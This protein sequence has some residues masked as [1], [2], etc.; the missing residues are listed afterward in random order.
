MSRNYLQLQLL[1]AWHAQYAHEFFLSIFVNVENKG[2]LNYIPKLKVASSILVARSIGKV[3]GS[4]RPDSLTL[5]IEVSQ[6]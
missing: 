2:S 3:Q 5:R 1:D 4:I 6:A